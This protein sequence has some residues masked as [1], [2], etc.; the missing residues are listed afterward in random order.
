MIISVYFLI[1]LSILLGVVFALGF[2]W[3]AK[4]NQFKD[5]EEPKYRM[6]REED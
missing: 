4:T 1:F 5:I 2:I 6:L 3:A